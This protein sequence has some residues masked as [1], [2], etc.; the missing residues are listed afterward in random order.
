M[1]ESLKRR[2]D[3]LK[4]QLQAARKIS[5]ENLDKAILAREELVKHS[6]V[7]TNMFEQPRKMM[8]SNL[9]LTRQV[10]ELQVEVQLARKEA[11]IEENEC[12]DKDIEMGKARAE[13]FDR[14]GPWEIGRA[15]V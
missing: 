11:M 14:P 4:A 2:N 9:E 1:I 7:A 5:I 3:A 15:H 12:V 6:D 10:G 8:A 13:L